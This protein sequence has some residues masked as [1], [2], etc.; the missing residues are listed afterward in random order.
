M[1]RRGGDHASVPADGLQDGSERLGRPQS[2]GAK[3][4]ILVV[5]D[6]AIGGYFGDRLIEA[7]PDVTFLVRPR[8]AAE[9]AKSGL[10]IKSAA[11]NLTVLEPATI[12]AD[13]LR[14]PFDL[15]LLSCI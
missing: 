13:G 12:V 1:D 4:R 15:V 10:N 11:G 8:R 5:G 14:E 3:M 6:G 7:G 2:T 9:L